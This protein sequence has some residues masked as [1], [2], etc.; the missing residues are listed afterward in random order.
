MAADATTE[1]LSPKEAV[2]RY[3]AHLADLS[4]CV[5]L[6][7]SPVKALH[8]GSNTEAHIEGFRYD[9]PAWAKAHRVMVDGGY[10]NFLR[11]LT[12]RLTYELPRVRATSFKP[13]PE[14]IFTNDAGLRCANTFVPF[15]PAMTADFVMPEMLEEYLSRALM[16]EQDRKHVV[17]WMADI[18]QNPTRRPQWAVVLTGQQGTGKSSISRLVSAAL[19][20]RHTW[21]GN[22]YTPA[23]QKFSEVLPDHLLVSFDDAVAGKD[24]YQVLKLGITRLSMK[25]EVKGQQKHVE[26]PVYARVLMCSNKTRPLR[27]DDEGDRRL[28]CAEYSTHKVDAAET[29]RFFVGFNA[30]MEHPDTPAIIRQWLMQVDLSDFVP[31][32]TVQTETHAQMVG[33]STSALDNCLADFIEVE[34]G[35]APAV[36]LKGTLL[37][38]LKAEHFPSPDQD[39]IKLKMINLGYELTRRVVKGCNAGKKVD[40]WQPRPKG[41][42]AP[43]LTPEQEDAIRQAF[44]AG[45]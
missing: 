28:Y 18:I 16:N 11:T 43:A 3:A 12:D 7:T 44:D 29:A 41:G 23:F 4:Y 42:R 8:I 34:E 14:R 26:R 1:R 45:F 30:W 32:S 27:I 22:S 10:S 39:S 25:V 13:V 17:Q 37:A 9:F 19:G 40:L 20:Y 38:H 2:R 6:S 36:F 21:E 24:T 15:A 31:G 33:L 35:A 5:D